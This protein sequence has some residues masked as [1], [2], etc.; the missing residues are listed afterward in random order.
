MT[1]EPFSIAD[2]AQDPTAVLHEPVRLTVGAMH[3]AGRSGIYTA[4]FGP[5]YDVAV[6]FDLLRLE[7]SGEITAEITARLTTPGLARRIHRARFNLSSTR[8][9]SE[10]AKHLGARHRGSDIPWAELLEQAIDATVE[11]H[12]AGEPAIRLVDAER[13]AFAGSMLG[14]LL[15]GGHPSIL[16][17]D[18]GTMKSYTALGA[19]LSL[20]TGEPVLGLPVER[21]LR[22]AYFDWEFSGWD[23]RERAQ[24]LLGHEDHDLVYVR[25][26]GPLVEEVDRLRRI[27]R[28]SAIDYAVVDSAAYACAGPPEAAEVAMA[29]FQAFARLELTAGGL[30]VAHVPKDGD[31]SKPFG[32]AFW[33]NSARIIWRTATDGEQLDGA[34]TVALYNTKS[35][36]TGRLAPMALRY[37]FEDDRIRVTRPDPLDVPEM[38]AKLPIRVR[39]SNALRHGAMTLAAIAVEIDEDVEAV[40]Q[41]AKRGA[42]PKSG[43]QPWCLFVTGPDGISRVGLAAAS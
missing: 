43:R 26:R 39:M 6:D 42:E 37:T 10:L 22:V 33:F 27:V 17:G 16:N 32:S 36:T 40:R 14:G 1:A 9:R 20:Q 28:E 3:F 35:N 19:A 31:G 29:F 4:A 23:H 15:V 25:C 41:A 8:T 5:P 2:L 11:A 7:R 13:P 18:G 30:I 34:T 21:R 38:A 12:R 24:A